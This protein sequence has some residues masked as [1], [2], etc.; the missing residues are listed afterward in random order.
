VAE[1]KLDGSGERGC[2]VSGRCLNEGVTPRK[3]M[4]LKNCCLLQ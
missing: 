3:G 2:D 4:V 1:V